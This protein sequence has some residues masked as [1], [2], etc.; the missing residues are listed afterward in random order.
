MACT[1]VMSSAATDPWIDPTISSGAPEPRA[2]VRERVAGPGL[3]PLPREHPGFTL[4]RLTAVLTVLM[5]AIS[6]AHIGG[7]AT[8]WI[9]LAAAM[10]WCVSWAH[11]VAAATAGLVTW[12]V[13]NGF[14]ENHFG[15]LTFS[16]RD[17]ERLL[18]LIAL[19]VVVAYL[20]RWSRRAS[21][22]R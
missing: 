16:A 2:V 22:A 20:T 18:A 6:A 8:S 15:Q 7:T 12:A 1:G 17:G 4:A 11:P 9:A 13:G 5:L 19:A 21:G 3:V 14:D 10:A